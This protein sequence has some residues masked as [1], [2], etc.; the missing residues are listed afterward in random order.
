[1]RDVL[2]F[3]NLGGFMAIPT[4][5]LAA[6]RNAGRPA[7]A[8]A[9]RTVPVTTRVVDVTP[10]PAQL[11]KLRSAVQSIPAASRSGIAARVGKK[12]V[13]IGGALVGVAALMAM[14]D[15][16]MTSLLSKASP[17]ELQAL[18][19]VLFG[20][21]EDTDRALVDVINTG[22]ELAKIGQIMETQ[23]PL[24]AFPA[25]PAEGLGL[26]A[27]DVE[28][29]EGLKA[30][31]AL[32]RARFSLDEIMALKWLDKATEADLQVLENAYRWSRGAR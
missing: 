2:P 25:P 14:N 27:S 20:N 31:Y 11:A 3:N 23:E 7:V 4:R 5:A 28:R 12:Q 10:S 1:M 29:Y 30:L 24:D 19:T 8:S 6:A 15:E 16:D 18:G 17:D 9:A 13:M 26:V 32:I 22:V 21:D